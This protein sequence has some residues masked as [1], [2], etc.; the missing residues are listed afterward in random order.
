MSATIE[1]P[2]LTAVSKP[3][4]S[5]EIEKIDGHQKSSGVK[6]VVTLGT[7]RQRH[8]YTNEILLVPTPSRDR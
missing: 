3:A 1:Q 7:I 5:E 8:E 2:A 6:R 4:E